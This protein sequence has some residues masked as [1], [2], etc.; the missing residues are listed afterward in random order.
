MEEG[1]VG[2]ERESVGTDLAVWLSDG[3][4]AY[5]QLK[6]PLLESARTLFAEEVADE[7]DAVAGKLS[8]DDPGLLDSLLDILSKYSFRQL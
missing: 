8:T 6:R 5:S 7:E 3:D 1:E 4:G 2:L